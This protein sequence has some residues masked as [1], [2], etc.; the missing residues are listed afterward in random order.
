MLTQI[1]IRNLAT[2]LDLQVN[3]HSSC[4][5][6]T[7]ETGAGKSIFIEAIEFALGGKTSRQTIHP[8]KDKAEVTL[9]F[10]LTNL[11]KVIESLQDHELYQDEPLCIIR[12]VLSQDGRS[13]SYIN[14]I[15]V[16]LQRVKSLGETLFYLHRQHAQHLLLRSETH[17]E[18]L[19]RYGNNL[20]L[21]LDVKKLAEQRASLKQKIDT[22]TSKSIEQN[23]LIGYLKFQLQELTAIDLKAGDWE[24]I[25]SEHKQLSQIAA[26]KNNLRLA[27]Q[28]LSQ[29]NHA[30]ILPMIMLLHKTV[31]TITQHIDQANIWLKTIA[32]IT[33]HLR[34]LESD[35]N[36]YLDGNPE[37]ETRIETL[38]TQ[39]KTVF[40]LSRKHKIPPTELYLLQEKIYQQLGDLERK[41]EQL[42]EMQGHLATIESQYQTKAKELSEKRKL[43]ASKL[44][45]EILAI[46]GSLSLPDGK[47]KIE[48]IGEDERF[49]HYGNEKIVFLMS[50]NRDQPQVL[51]KTISGGELSRLSLALHLALAEKM[52]TPTLVFDEIDTGLS[53]A[54]AEKVGKLLRRLGDSYQ[55]FCV[56]HQAPVAVWGHHHLLVEKQIHQQNTQT[57]LRLLTE[58]EKMHEIARLL[59]GEKITPKT[60]A[61]AQEM[62]N[63]I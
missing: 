10:D 51:L 41:G 49:N 4:T 21:A 20:S 61:H 54:A 15:P 7:G 36:H 37:D 34:D 56:T 44:Q 50:T 35:L 39:I 1:H 52:T 17:R 8:G 13:R 23:Q 18:M 43:A 9:I 11:P 24:K 19:D 58:E 57:E 29:D 55:V 59:A 27:L 22:L 5:M 62:L 16:L 46:L 30:G 47:F 40:D 3:L 60:I 12:R 45:A 32:E 63:L 31:S 38:E 33:L 2:I 6:I 42:V 28:Y 26:A 53:G 25:E 14:G 48:L